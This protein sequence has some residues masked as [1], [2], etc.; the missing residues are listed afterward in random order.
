MDWAALLGN[1]AFLQL[2][3]SIVTLITKLLDQHPQMAQ[4]LLERA[5]D[6]LGPP[7]GGANG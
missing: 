1:P 4:S 7:S 2:V 6:R 3:N 5:V